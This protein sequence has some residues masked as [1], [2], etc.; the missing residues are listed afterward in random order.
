MLKICEE[1]SENL[2]KFLKSFE[3]IWSKFKQILENF[4][5]I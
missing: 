2:V 1:I 5:I 4:K 3:R